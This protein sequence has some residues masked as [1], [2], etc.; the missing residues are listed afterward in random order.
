MS[1]RFVIG[2]AGSGKTT[3]CQHQIAE[4]CRADPLGPPIYWLLPRQATFQAERLLTCD[5]G[6]EAFA[7][8]RIYS[9]EQL[10]QDVLA[11]CGGLAIPQI[12]AASRQMIL[13]MLISRLSDKFQYFHSSANQARLA[14][15]LDGT[16]AEIERAGH[17][18]EDLLR[19]LQDDPSQGAFPSASPGTREVDLA[20]LPAKLH[21]LQLLYDH[22]LRYLGQDRLDPDRRQRQV[23][24]CIEQWP[25]LKGADVYVDGFT[26]FSD[27][28]RQTLTSIARVC[29][30]LHITLLMDTASSV[31]GN[32]HQLPPDIDLFHPCQITYRKLYFALTAGNIVLYPPLKLT[33]TPRFASQ[34]LASLEATLFDPDAPE[35]ISTNQNS[36]G[37]V[38]AASIQFIEA[39]D[40]RAEVDA[41]ANTI[42]QLQTQGLRLRDI[43][44]LVRNLDPCHDLIQAGFSEHQI[45]F[46]ADRRRTVAHH[47][48]L[49]LCRHILLVA[50]DHWPQESIV[51]ILKSGLAGLSRADADFL[52]NYARQHHIH[53]A[54]WSDPAPWHL[55]LSVPT[56]NEDLDKSIEDSTE[57]TGLTDDLGTTLADWGDLPDVPNSSTAVDV[58]FID[59]PLTDMGQP[60]A[61]STHTPGSTGI[62]GSSYTT[63]SPDSPTSDPAGKSKQQ[64]DHQRADRL[65]R[66]IADALS[67]FLAAVR[68][69]SS[70][71]LAELVDHLYQVIIALGARDAMAQWMAAADLATEFQQRDE[72]EQVWREL[73]E[74]LTSLRD[75]LGTESIPLSRFIQILDAG[76]ERFDLGLTPPTVDQVLVGQIDRTHTSN[77]KAVLVLG[78][79]DG[80][81]PQLQQED[82]IFSDVDRRGL[83]R[84]NIDI[85]P[86][87][88]RQLLDEHLLAYIAFTRASQQLTLIRSTGGDSRSKLDPSVFWQML[89]SRCPD[90]VVQSTS[91]QDIDRSPQSLNTPRQLITG[92]MR[93]ARRQAEASQRAG[94]KLLAGA[95]KRAG[96]DQHTEASQSA[97]TNESMSLA[98]SDAGAAAQSSDNASSIVNPSVATNTSPVPDTEHPAWACL[99]QWLARRQTVGDTIDVMRYRA[100]HAL[101]YHNAPVLPAHTVKALWHDPFVATARQLESFASCPFQHFVR[102]V[103]HLDNELTDDRAT[104]LD[105]SGVYHDA[106]RQLVRLMIRDHLDWKTLPPATAHRLAA[107]GA[108][109]AAMRIRKSILLS[110]ARNRQ[111]LMF[112]QQS[113]RRFIQ[114]QQTLATRQDARPTAAGISF[115]HDESSL[116]ALTIHT[117]AGHTLHLAGSIDRVDQIT[118][119]DASGFALIDY[120]LSADSGNLAKVQIGVELQLLTHMLYLS[121][122]GTQINPAFQSPAA[123]WNVPLQRGINSV[124]HPDEASESESDKFILAAKPA[125]W[126][127]QRFVYALDN[128]MTHGQ[129]SDALNVRLTKDGK[130]YASSYE[131]ISEVQFHN[132]LAFVRQLLGQI[133]DDVLGGSIAV[134][135]YR[136]G[137]TSPCAQCKMHRLCRFEPSVDGYHFVQVQDR[138]SILDASTSTHSEQPDAD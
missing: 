31:L 59:S 119:S 132:L 67:P 12:S 56:N 125:G 60:Q 63:S 29:S 80:S 118:T 13:A 136:L 115:G 32:V 1:V 42:R 82:S 85:L 17:T 5:S 49:Q 28:Q 116:P 103:L 99:Y 57:S 137:D 41:A 6:L 133:A 40:F 84:L 134:K 37:T 25:A 16:L 62:T 128:K 92:L 122:Q 83:R 14:S 105:L 27:H 77:I 94:T 81:F 2:R 68:G 89:L 90:A 21:D 74:L 108:Q 15:C 64:T 129:T 112:L 4:A 70:L 36:A 110:D 46:F 102:H 24:G 95:Q 96:A 52:E 48:L 47:P 98:N 120:R 104:G 55:S 123:G 66:H 130:P 20:A 30:N 97:G 61:A 34:A 79:N 10:G 114:Q 121:V 117:P 54:A 135:P 11:A 100:W 69:K 88:Q 26:E 107:E 35:T 18:P 91:Q 86:D 106:L 22:Y 72:H 131:V 71:P 8:A 76:L 58:S 126:I 53:H 75:I 113:L 7:R 127:N 93:W 51:A 138:L 44:V 111:T 19:Q 33:S 39:P 9:F 109:K 87:T 43:A 101:S 73:V 3:W 124:K 45:P 65:R 23:L 78:L 50:R 38:S